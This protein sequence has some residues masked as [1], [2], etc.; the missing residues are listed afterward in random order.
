MNRFF[1]QF[2]LTW[3]PDDLYYKKKTGVWDKGTNKSWAYFLKLMGYS[4]NNLNPNEAIKSFEGILN[5]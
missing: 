4:G 3:D 5:K 1:D 2:V